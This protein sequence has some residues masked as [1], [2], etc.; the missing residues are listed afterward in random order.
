MSVTENLRLA[1]IMTEADCSQKALARGVNEEAARH[2]KRLATT[3]SLVSKWLHGVVP[4]QETCQYIATV[5]SKRIGRR[6]SLA[7]VGMMGAD[8]MPALDGLRFADDD[9][10]AVN[11]LASLWGA[12][13]ADHPGAVTSGVDSQ[14]WRD[15]SLRW[16]IGSR[17]QTHSPSK[18]IGRIGLGD[19]TAMRMT[20]EV[21]AALDNR[22]GGGHGRRALIQY[23]NSDV[24]PLLSADC[25][26]A[27]RRELFATVS[28]ATL[29]AAW[30]CYDTGLHGLAQRYF[31]QALRMAQTAGD[32]RLA[33][34]VLSAMSHQA[35]FIGRY[36]DAVDLARAGIAGIATDGTPTLRAQFH[37]MEARGLARLGDTRQCDLAM[38]DAVTQF[39]RRNVDDEPAWIT[40]FNEAE[41]AAEMG[42]CFRDLGRPEGVA[43]HLALDVAQ[44]DGTN[45]R[46]DF[47]ATMVLADAHAAAGEAEEAC[48]VAGLAM[49]AGE[50]LKSARCAAYV[51]EFRRRLASLGPNLAVRELELQ[52]AENPLWLAAS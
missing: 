15:A 20:L 4:Q 27:A 5:L 28:E 42:H 3:H 25:S 17:S 24:V 8:P 13:L 30:S 49:V 40:Y 22:F 29:L 52:V 50:Q 19:I 1:K 31:I 18:S 9:S 21:F 6:L 23:L 37:A 41:L 32:R 47:F 44:G 7:D 48:R 43:Q 34:S 45:V 51:T 12:D 11:V 33:S 46:S 39:D 10:D 35:T 38:A 2:G 26:E 14:A 36:R 16:L